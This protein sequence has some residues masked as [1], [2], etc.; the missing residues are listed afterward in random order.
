L[1]KITE[2]VKED[3]LPE[4]RLGNTSH[5]FYCF[6]KFISGRSR[7]CFRWQSQSTNREMCFRVKITVAVPLKLCREVS[8]KDLCVTLS[9]CHMYR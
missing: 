9:S 8:G 1:F 7:K 6:L 5:V 4:A 2:Q 3:P